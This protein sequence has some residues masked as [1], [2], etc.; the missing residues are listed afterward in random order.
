MNISEYEEEKYR[1][2]WEQASYRVSNLAIQFWEEYCNHIT[3]TNSVV[4]FGCGSGKLVDHL[5]TLG[6]EAIGFDITSNSVNAEILE[7]YPM[8]FLFMPLWEIQPKPLGKYDIGICHDVMEHIPTELV[9]D[10]FKAILHTANE[11]Y[12][13][14]EAVLDYA[15]M[16][17]KEPLHLTVEPEEW[18]IERMKEAGGKVIVLPQPETSSRS[19]AHFF[20]LEN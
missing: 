8:N 7:K 20:K 12:F 13:L 1:N 19:L 11:T 4:D 18:W 6:Y 3:I 5:L 9:V 17:G 10:T 16:H 2:V 15:G 14:I